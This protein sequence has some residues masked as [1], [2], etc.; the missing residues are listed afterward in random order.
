[1]YRKIALTSVSLNIAFALVFLGVFMPWC[2]DKFKDLKVEMPM[3]V[4][5]LVNASHFVTSPLGLVASL[6]LIGF[7]GVKVFGKRAN[8][9]A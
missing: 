1:M 2:M 4:M 8:I 7:F 3:P 6:L 5:W 9:G